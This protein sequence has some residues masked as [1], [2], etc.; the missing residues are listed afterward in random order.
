MSYRLFIDDERMPPDDG[1][2]Y[3]IVRNS[4]EALRTVVDRGLPSFISFDH[5]L[6][7]DDTAM[8]FLRYLIDYCLDHGLT[9]ADVSY[10]VHSQNPIG[11]QNIIGLWESFQR[12]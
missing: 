3:V 10:Y 5:D 8:I 4:D 11:K 1:T 6:G 9:L 7:G 2:T 12:Q